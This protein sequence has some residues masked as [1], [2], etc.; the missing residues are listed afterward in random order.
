[1]VTFL[2]QGFRPFFLCAGAFAILLMAMWMGTLFAG[3]DLPVSVPPSLWHGHE[4]LFGFAGAAV[5]GFLLTALPEWTGRR[6]VTPAGL[7]VLLLVWGIGRIA[8]S[9]GREWPPVL[10]IAADIAFLPA[11]AIYAGTTLVMARRWRNLVVIAVLMVLFAGNVV[12]HAALFGWI[13]I[14]PRVGLI[15]TLD[16]FVLLVTIIGGRVVPAFTENALRRLGETVTIGRTKGL[17]IA[18]VVTVA[19]II[20]SDLFDVESPISGAVTLVA[21]TA[22]ALCLLTWQSERTVKMP[23][24]WVLHL[25]YLWLVAGLFMKGLAG[26]LPGLA[27]LVWVHALTVGAMST[28]I[29][30]IMS[31]AA[32]GHTGRALI[33]ARPVA[34][35]YGLVSLS[36]IARIISPELP[37]PW[38]DAALIAA[39]VIWSLAFATFVAV[40]WPILT[41]PGL[42]A[43]SE[44]DSQAR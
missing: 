18:A 5:A 8:M 17:D 36:A 39:G 27:G 33:A 25:G 19:A 37:G 21:A 41:Q 6:S 29:L 1:M 43:T 26:L 12:F 14:A 31:R 15:L 22:N 2:S 9:L 4:M 23:I 44:G 20:P 13:D 32:L 34:A 10:M 16:G 38:S 40:Y 7:T 24:L 11:L 30:A 28:M 35:S 3:W 42:K